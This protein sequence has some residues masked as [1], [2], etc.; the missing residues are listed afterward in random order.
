MPASLFHWKGGSP[1]IASGA[2]CAGLLIVCTCIVL[3][4]HLFVI[5]ASMPPLGNGLSGLRSNRAD[6]SWP[7]DTMSKPVKGYKLRVMRPRISAKVFLLMVLK[8]LARGLL[9]Q[10]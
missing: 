3:N 2:A 5:F 7:G 4:R 10:E 6:I 1:P 9:S 8:S